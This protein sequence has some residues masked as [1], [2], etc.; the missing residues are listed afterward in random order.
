MEARVARFE[1]RVNEAQLRNP[2]TRELVRNAVLRKGAS[3]CPVRLKRLSLDVIIRHGDALSGLFCEYPDDA[4]F[5]Q[6]YDI[7]VGFQPP[8][9][10]DRIN[11][12]E[13]LMRAAEWTDEWGVRWGHAFGGVGA[14]PVAYPIQ[15]WS[16]LDDYLA[17]RLPDPRARGRFDAARALLDQHRATKF[18]VG[19]VHLAFFERMHGLRGMENLF[20]D[21]GTHEEEIRRLLDALTVYLVEVVRC[22]A[23]IGA[24]AIFLTDDWGSQTSLMISPRMWR[25]YFKA[26]YQAV[27]EAIHAC[28]MQIIFHSCGNV[29][30]IVPD[31][32]EIGVD[33]LDPVQPGAMDHEEVARRFG[34]RIAFCGAIDDQ[35]LLGSCSPARIKDTVRRVVDTLGAPFRNALILSPGNVITPEVPIENL[36]ALFE[37]C[38][39]G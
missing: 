30:A 18:C 32:I 24:D 8:E 23:E 20:A 29:T 9:K 12:V 36:R 15:D 16:Q 17:H 6:P 22:W 11:P 31:L 35:H 25:S 34:G 4:L 38:H 5:I 33:V 14:T 2:P 1:E 39:G 26:H 37:A 10:E 27:V 3:R 19:C 13:V 7:F 28:G 21:L